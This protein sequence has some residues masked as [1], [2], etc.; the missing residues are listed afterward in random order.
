M[1]VDRIVLARRA[2]RGG[3]GLVL[4]PS[5]AGNDAAIVAFLVSL[6]SDVVVPLG[7]G[8]NHVGRRLH[9]ALSRSLESMQWLLR[10]D[11][12]SASVSDAYTTNGTTLVP[13]GAARDL[14]WAHLGVGSAAALPEPG[15]R[16]EHPNE[17]ARRLGL[18]QG[19]WGPLQGP[20]VWYPLNEG[21]VLV[22][23]QAFAFAWCVETAGRAGG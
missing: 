22:S 6:S 7:A 8:V 9:E 15:V 10:C 5:G 2:M 17:T 18:A 11:A 4:T 3:E 20:A 19:M 12:G 23:Y 13:H 16:L 1:V 14:D 21:D